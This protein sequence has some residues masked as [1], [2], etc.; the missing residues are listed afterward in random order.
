MTSMTKLLN[1]KLKSNSIVKVGG[2]FDV[3]SGMLVEKHGFDVIW[4]GGFGISA[5]R[6]SS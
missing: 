4:A 5:V 1:K 2:A 6:G 3:M